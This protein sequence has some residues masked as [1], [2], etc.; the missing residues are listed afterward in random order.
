MLWKIKNLEMQVANKL[1]W[2]NR[3]ISYLCRTYDQLHHGQDYSEAKTVIHIGFLDYTLFPDSSEFYSTYKLMNVNNHRIY[4]DNLILRVLDLTQINLATS[5]DKAYLIDYWAALFKAKTWEE[6]KMLAE[7][8]EY[9]NE[10]SETMFQLSADELIKKRCRDREEYY[11]DLRNYERVIAEMKNTIKDK[12]TAI[13]NITAEK[14]ASLSQLEKL[15]SEMEKLRA[16]N[17]ALKR[18]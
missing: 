1:N 14:E 3:S 6:I 13:A 4:S 9:L 12:D 5:E 10:A 8:N 11:Q 7:K 17:E 15:T 16:E 18:Q 2:Q